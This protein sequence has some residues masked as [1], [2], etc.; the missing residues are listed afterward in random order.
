MGPTRRP[1]AR[2]AAEGRRQGGGAA[3][4][5]GVCRQA[6]APCAGVRRGAPHRGKCH[7][8]KPPRTA[9]WQARGAGGWSTVRA[10]SGAKAMHGRGD[11]EG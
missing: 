6:R 10:A 8:L 1:E 2:A 5:A 11:T 3:G 7:S 4:Q 9:G